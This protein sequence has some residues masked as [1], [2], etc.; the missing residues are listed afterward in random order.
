MTRSQNRYTLKIKNI[1]ELN[2]NLR[3]KNA[4]EECVL[5]FDLHS[6]DNEMDSRDKFPR[7]YGS[8]EKFYGG[9]SI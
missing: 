2:I 4:R 7:D 6:I 8:P 3:P 5:L 9:G 1:P